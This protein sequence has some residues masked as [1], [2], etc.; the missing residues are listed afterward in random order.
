MKG[1]NNVNTYP[2]N[3]L[4]ANAALALTICCGCAT[5]YDQSAAGQREKQTQEAPANH[6]KA[7]AEQ[8]VSGKWSAPDPK[9][10]AYRDPAA[11][12]RKKEENIRKLTGYKSAVTTRTQFDTDFP[13]KE[14]PWGFEIFEARWQSEDR[15]LARKRIGGKLDQELGNVRT[16]AEKVKGTK[17]TYRLGYPEGPI[18]MLIFAGDGEKLI[19]STLISIDPKSR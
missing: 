12:E 16:E 11:R 19:D 4:L 9:A 13:D 7:E 6:N 17:S 14:E 3:T 18:Y 1:K 10:A 2:A 15:F 5:N 8:R